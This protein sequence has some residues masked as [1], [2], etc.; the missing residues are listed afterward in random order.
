MAFFWVQDVA[1]TVW[2]P[3]SA[4]T[5]CGSL[6]RSPSPPGCLERETGWAGGKDGK[7]SGGEGGK[8]RKEGKE[9]KKS[10]GEWRGKEVAPSSIAR[11]RLCYVLL[12]DGGWC[13]CLVST[14]RTK[15]TDSSAY[16]RTIVPSTCGGA[17][18]LL[19]VSTTNNSIL[20]GSLQDKLATVIHVSVIASIYPTSLISSLGFYFGF[21]AFL[22]I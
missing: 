2:R 20:H 6:Q 16:V 9:E 10:R 11:L 19:Y 3:G 1:K 21:G 15:V 5:R 13:N 14:V 4:R 7:R 12:Y 8:R 18:G 17:D 22:I